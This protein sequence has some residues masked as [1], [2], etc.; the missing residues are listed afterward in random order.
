MKGAE[1]SFLPFHQTVLAFEPVAISTGAKGVRLI[2]SVHDAANF[3][4]EEWPV[5]PEE[6]FQIAVNACDETF[7]GSSDTI[8][9]RAA[10]VRAAE[11]A[12]I[13]QP[14]AHANPRIETAD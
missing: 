1:L 4:L 14:V 11:V 3:L 8:L 6:M 12:G 2:S 13:L 9:A 5:K 10:F 7:R